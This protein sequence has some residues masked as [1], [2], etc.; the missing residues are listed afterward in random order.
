M[1]LVRSD[2]Q[3]KATQRISLANPLRPIINSVRN[4]GAKTLSKIANALGGR[5]IR[6]ARGNSWQLD[7]PTK[8][9]CK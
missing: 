1:S 7:L 4:S 6:P 9:V 8:L 3:R 5:G 2:A